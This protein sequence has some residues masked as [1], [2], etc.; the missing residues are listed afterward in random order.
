MAHIDFNEVPRAQSHAARVVAAHPAAEDGLDV[1]LEP[2]S[3]LAAADGLD[4]SSEPEF[5]SASADKL[6]LVPEP[7]SALA[8]E[9]ELG[10]A[11][12]PDLAAED[13]D[14]LTPDLDVEDAPEPDLAAED[15]DDRA[16]ESEPVFDEWVDIPF[17]PEHTP[18]A[19]DVEDFLPELD[20][21]DDVWADIPSE[22]KPEAATADEAERALKPASHLVIEFVDE[23][24][25]QANFTAE[26]DLTPESDENAVAD[27]SA[28]PLAVGSITE[29]GCSEDG[30][31]SAAQARWHLTPAPPR[32]AQMQRHQ[33]MQQMQMPPPF[34]PAASWLRLRPR[35]SAC[36][37]CFHSSTPLRVPR[38]QEVSRKGQ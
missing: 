26:D 11:L 22:A 35:H 21:A 10:L 6:T 4:V 14:D 18:A 17:E 19:E 27:E 9:D 12:E 2:E 16:P 20:P 29:S 28:T 8:A 31:D 33:Q 36:R 24:P 7:E 23:L 32:L 38:R 25:S 34:P 5:A 3:A 1:L 30:E 37:C 15:E 13:E